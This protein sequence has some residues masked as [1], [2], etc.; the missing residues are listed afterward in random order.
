MKLQ[1]S[2]GKYSIFLPTALVQAM[3]WKKGD[4]LETKFLGKDR[5]EIRKK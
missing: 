5:L 3:M 1:E 2:G 4:T